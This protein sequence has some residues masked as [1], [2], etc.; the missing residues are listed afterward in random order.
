MRIIIKAKTNILGMLTS[1]IPQNKVLFI[2][3]FILMEAEHT[4]KDQKVDVIPEK[5]DLPPFI[6]IVTRVFKL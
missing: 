1:L 3:T 4:Q 6:S 2:E 5:K